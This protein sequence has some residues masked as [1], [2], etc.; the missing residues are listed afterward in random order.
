MS[1]PAGRAALALVAA[2]ALAATSVPTAPGAEAHRRPPVTLTNA[3]FTDGLRGWEVTGDRAAAKV[4]ADGRTEPGRLTHWAADPYDVTTSQRVTGLRTGWWTASAWVKSGGLGATMLA[5]ECAG[6]RHPRGHGHQGRHTQPRRPGETG[7]TAASHGSVTLPQT[8]QDDAWVRVTASAYS[9]GG[10]CAVRVTTSDPDGGAWASVDDVAVERGRV[11]RDVRGGDL[12]GLAK[13]EDHGATYADVDGSPGDAVEILADHGMNLGRLKVWVDP[14]DGYNEVTHVVAAARRIQAA[15]MDVMVDFHYSDRWTDPG[16]QGV[17]AAWAASSVEGMTAQLADHTREVMS[18][19]VDAGVDVA[20]AQVGNEIN[21]GMLWPYGQTWD[22]AA[23]DGVDGAQWDTLA[24]FLTAGH[25]AVKEISPGTET[26]LHLTNIN[27][28]IGSLTWWFDEVTARGVPFDVVG[29]SYYG[30]W[31]GSLADLQ[32]A[33]STLSARYDRDVL[34][35]ETAYPFTLADDE[36]AWENVIDLESE[37]V[38]G[39]PATP[40]GQAAAFRAVQDVVAAAPGKRGRGAVYWEPAWTAVE[41]N[42]W[43]PEDPTSGN[44]WEN[45]AV[46]DHDGRLLGPVAAALAP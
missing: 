6:E 10:A 17:P 18:A 12:S 46:F 34:V 11:T 27:N 5:L 21:P 7:R 26:I 35:V 16:A 31:H 8:L 39:Y 25:D 9:T 43:D 24:G 29:L 22:V 1:G 23:G 30:Y 37:L 36:P 19:L 3:G 13:N 14:A 2:G 40:E 42:G 33:V 4:E 41:G 45:Q 38:A 32:T 15:G 44:A 28:G 20:Y